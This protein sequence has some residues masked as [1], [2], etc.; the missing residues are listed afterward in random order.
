MNK[1]QKAREVFKLKIS[2]F[3]TALALQLPLIAGILIDN[4]YIKL[5]GL[6]WV[7]LNI[8]FHSAEYFGAYKNHEEERIFRDMQ[9][10]LKTKQHFEV[11][12]KEESDD[13]DET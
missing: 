6:F 1:K 12:K 8:V 2:I 4:P 9:K 7:F 10:V 5:L 11:Y 3:L 13:Y